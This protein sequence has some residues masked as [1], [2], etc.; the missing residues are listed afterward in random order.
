M[1]SDRYLEELDMPQHDLTGLDAPFPKEEVWKTLCSL[2]SNKAPGLDGFTGNFYK[3]W[4]AIIKSDIM[5]AISAVWS[6]KFGNFGLLNSAYITL[7]I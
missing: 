7:D 3:A 5:A 6:R 1:R 2:P 4:W